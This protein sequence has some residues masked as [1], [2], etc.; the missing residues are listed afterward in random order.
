MTYT[1]EVEVG[2]PAD[3]QD[4]GDLQI[5]K[6]A[7]GEMNNNAYLLRC[8]LTGEQV[9][10]DAAAEHDRL[11]E[12]IG[13]DGL[14]AI[15][16]THRHGDHW[17]ALETLVITTGAETIAGELDADELPVPVDRRVQTGARVRV[18]SCELEVIEI[19]GHTPGSI[20]LAYDDPDGIV[21]L[22]TG[23]SLFPG[24]VGKTWSPEDFTTLVG[25][26]ETKIFGRF[27]DDTHVYPGHGHDTTLGV[28]RPHLAEWR[29]RGW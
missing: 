4:A 21:H 13:D 5:T 17:Q 8:N 19:A 20:A 18:G 15:V 24:G 10:I 27:P 16:T 6:I 28:E 14:S 29:E 22:F 2:G 11:L 7:V 25:E 9:L 23:D 12:L 26:V 1:G 3:V